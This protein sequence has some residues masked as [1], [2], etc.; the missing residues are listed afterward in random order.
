MIRWA[1]MRRWIF[2]GVV[3]AMCWMPL[4][5]AFASEQT[6]PTPE[7]LKFFETSVRPVLA[8]NCYSCHGP[9]KHKN[10]LRLDSRAAMLAGGKSGPAIAPGDPGK[11]LL[12]AAV[13][14]VDADLKMPQDKPKLA[15][16]DI[17]ALRQWIELGAPW[18]PTDAADAERPGVIT[19]EDRQWWAFQPL[20]YV[21]PPQ[22]GDDAWSLNPIDRFIHARLK[23]DGL[24]PA[25]RAEKTALI[26]RACFDLLGIPPTPQQIDEFLAD[27]SS[28]AWPKLID[29]LLASPAY[30]ERWARHWFDLVRY[31]ESDGYRQDAYRPHIWRYR[32]YVIRSFN[33]DK[34]YD[35][36]IREQIAGT[37]ID[38]HAPEMIVASGFL[39]LGIYEYNIRD[40]ENQQRIILEDLTDIAGD[41]FLGLSMGCAKCHNHKF[42]PILQTDYY[43]LQAFFAPVLWRDDL[44]AASA[45]QQRE[46]AQ[47]LRKWEQAT[48]EIRAEVEKIEKPH[49]DAAR[50][51]AVNMFIVELRDIYNKPAAQRT[52]YEQ[53]IAYLIHRQVE[54]EY[55]RLDGKIKGEEREKWGEL[56]RQ[57]A[58]F[59]KLKPAELPPAMAATDVGLHAPPTYIPGDRSKRVIEPGFLTVLGDERP[60]ITPPPDAPSTGRRTALA[61]WLTRPDHPLTTRVIVNRVWQ[62]HFGRGLVGTSSDFGRL[63]DKPSHPELLDYLAVEFV[64]RGWSFKE[65]HRLIMTSETYRQSALRPAPQIARMKDPENHLLWRQ[66]TRRLDAEQIRDAMLAASG[67]L[68]PD[69][70]GPSADGAD[71][72]RSIYLK[73]VRNSP[74]PLLGVF[75]A[76]DGFSSTPRRNATTTATQSLMMINGAWPLARAEAFAKRLRQIEDEHERVEMAYRLAFGRLPDSAEREAALAFL[77]RA[78]DAAPR[79]AG[80]KVVAQAMP[81]GGQAALI[82]DAA[83]VDQFRFADAAA[84]PEGDFTIEAI[85]QLNSIYESAAVRT[86]AAQWTG[87]TK[88][89]G[90]SLGVTSQQ[91]RYQP[92]NLILQLVGDRGYEVVA[93]NLRLDLHR[94]YYVAAVV[95]IADTREAGVTFYLKDLSDPDVPMY[96]ANV[97]HN[98]TGKYHSKE[99]L[100]IAGRHGTASHGWDGL[101]DDVRLTAAA[102]SP[103]QLLINDG[104]SVPQTVGHW[105]F[106]NAPG[107]FKDSSGR[108]RHLTRWPDA[109]NTADRSAQEAALVDFCHALF[110]ASEFLYVD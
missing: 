69:V 15:E 22:V 57:L 31:A 98:V 30:G 97:K 10:D 11:S 104:S 55:E 6:P 106:E 81:H 43:K 72:R 40:A 3:A 32:D 108:D 26:R 101:I 107:F 73:V 53:Q 110:N 36:F 16:H 7:Q 37:E 4:R 74:D 85:V 82:R 64:K 88:H 63:G 99:P 78:G 71:P 1:W 50:D 80:E 91:S 70:G 9:D 59:E 66:N 92:R 12:I 102:L 93:S 25:E 14:H 13:T 28:D 60:H 5:A 58:E 24:E 42:D 17:A 61:D 29:R 87:N 56:K 90:W 18:P 20:K 41:V 100:S 86:I 23:A 35:Q 109:V 89:P 2:A 21:T 48:A 75:D 103:Q 33:S 46:Y 44:S 105:R 47:Q 62:Y 84:L 34:P 94:P 77:R 38:P 68:D 45:Q 65:L 79:E 95:K 39:R 67:E 76:P 27:D 83:P 8:E 52:P 54:F 49:R 96:T 51:K 19:N